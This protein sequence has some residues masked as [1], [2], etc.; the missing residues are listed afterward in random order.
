[1]FLAY[2]NIFLATIEIGVL[3]ELGKPDLAA[4]IFLYVSALPGF[5]KNYYFNNSTTA[6][7][8]RFWACSRTETPS[9][10]VIPESAP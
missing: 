4:F 1:M 9:L 10:S 5:V 2:C 8:P 7:Y 3:A 6:A